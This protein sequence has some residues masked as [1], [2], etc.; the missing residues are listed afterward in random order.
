MGE[1]LFRVGDRVGGRGRE[2]RRGG[3]RRSIVFRKI[4]DIECKSS[5]GRRGSLRVF[6]G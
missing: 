1:G 4:L 5:E 6:L 2:E 3:R